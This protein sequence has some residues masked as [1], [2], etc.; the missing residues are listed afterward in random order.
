MQARHR[1]AII[2]LIVALALFI[3]RWPLDDN[4]CNPKT[5]PWRPSPSEG[6]NF[7]SSVFR[8]GGGTPAIF[9]MLGGQRYVIAN[10]MWNYTDVLF[11][12]GKLFEMIDPYESTVTLDPTFTDAWSTYGWHLAW[13]INSAV[14]DPVQKAKWLEA[15]KNVYIRA[16]R[17]NPK[18]PNARFDLAWLYQ[19]REGNYRKALNVLEPVVYPRAGY[20]AFQPTPA[21]TTQTTS[22][23]SLYGTDENTWDPE[24]IGHDLAA[25]YQKVAIYTGDPTYLQKSIDTYEKCW[26]LNPQKE[27][28]TPGII[29]DL[30]THEHNNAWVDR[31]WLVKQQEVEGRLRFNFGMAPVRRDVPLDKIFPDGDTEIPDSVR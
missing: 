18:K 28:R 24:R 1:S 2:L 3:V 30:E 26:K 15:G 6:T 29:R 22:G 27:Q 17:A 23:S 13:N 8:G 4:V 9:A 16:I 14:V 10:I 19:Q 12:Q 20:T 5:W 7:F 25:L 31:A 21:T 11:H